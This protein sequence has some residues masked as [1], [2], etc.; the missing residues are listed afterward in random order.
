LNN[1]K[2]WSCNI[3]KESLFVHYNGNILL[4]NCGVGGIIGNITNLNDVKIPKAATICN[5]EVCHCSADMVISK[6]I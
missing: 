5:K 1:F 2:N 3:G 4:G 6:W